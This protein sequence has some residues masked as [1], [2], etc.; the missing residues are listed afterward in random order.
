M[1]ESLVASLIDDIEFQL[2]S[3]PPPTSEEAP[4][5]DERRMSSKQ[6]RCHLV[7]IADVAGLPVCLL[8]RP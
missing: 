4:L 5:V 1:S 6:A 2:D 8:D 7:G 3:E